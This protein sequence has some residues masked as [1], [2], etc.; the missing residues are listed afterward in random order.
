MQIQPPIFYDTAK[1]FV[2]VNPFKVS[3]DIIGRVGIAV[4][5]LDP[6][7]P[8]ILTMLYPF[9]TR[10]STWGS[11][12]LPIWVY[13]SWLNRGGSHDGRDCK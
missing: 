2:E 5:T 12:S 6:L 11:H 10:Q 9:G 13:F 1:L 8:V 3:S 7:I 4:V